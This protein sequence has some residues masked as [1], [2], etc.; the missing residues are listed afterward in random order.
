MFEIKSEPV[1]FLVYL[2]PQCT[3]PQFG[4]SCLDLTRSDPHCR[5]AAA[6]E[7]FNKQTAFIDASVVYGCHEVEGQH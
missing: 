2:K 6:A 1:S 3:A 4:R 7:Q 5:P